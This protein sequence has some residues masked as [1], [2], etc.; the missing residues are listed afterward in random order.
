MWE[1]VLLLIVLVVLLVPSAAQREQALFIAYIFDQQDRA[2]LRA[3]IES[4][5][6]FLAMTEQEKSRFLDAAVKTLW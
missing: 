4:D 5:P 3:L 6:E 2:H 1:T